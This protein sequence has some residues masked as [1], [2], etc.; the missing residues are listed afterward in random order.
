MF[1]MV[2]Y[3]Q[4]GNMTVFGQNYGVSFTGFQVRVSQPASNTDQAILEDWAELLETAVSRNWFLCLESRKFLS[5][6]DFCDACRTM[7]IA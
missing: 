6:A 1:M 3:Q 2:E 4:E 5:K 7:C